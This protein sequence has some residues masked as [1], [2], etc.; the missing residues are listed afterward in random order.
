MQAADGTWIPIYAA[1]TRDLKQRL[2]GQVRL[3]DAVHSGATHIHAHY[4][5][6]RQAARCDEERD[7]IQRWRPEHNQ[8]IEG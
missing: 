7:L 5:S 6:S 4:G 8:R 1:Q 2:E 3:A